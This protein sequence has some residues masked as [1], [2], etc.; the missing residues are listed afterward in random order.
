MRGRLGG[1]GFTPLWIIA[2]ALSLLLI[3]ITDGARLFTAKEDG[4]AVATLL[5][6]GLDGATAEALANETSFTLEGGARC[7]L[8]S[9]G[10]IA[11]ES[12]LFTDRE[13]NIRSLPSAHLLCATVTLE[14]PG[15]ATDDGFLAGGSRR[16][17]CGARVRIDG[18][19]TTAT[20]LLL[21]LSEA[22]ERALPSAF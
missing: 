12:V 20:G 19:K 4:H 6:E 22:T 5:L 10:E 3:L 2:L 8:L 17:L 13:G 21:S 1:I 14:I 7:R 18:E 11:P 9:L 16:L 15:R